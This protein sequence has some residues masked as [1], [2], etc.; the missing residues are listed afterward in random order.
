M[1]ARLADM[2]QDWPGSSGIIEAAIRGRRYPVCLAHVHPGQP[3][4]K[5]YQESAPG[6]IVIRPAYS[7]LVPYWDIFTLSARICNPLREKE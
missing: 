4:E 3:L 1:A 2:L 7:E 6:L 5:E